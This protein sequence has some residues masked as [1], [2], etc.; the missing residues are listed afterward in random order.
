M[1]FSNKIFNNMAFNNKIFNDGMFNNKILMMVYS[2]IQYSSVR[3]LTIISPIIKY[4]T[5]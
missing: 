4:S 1:M 5:I 2:T 3:C